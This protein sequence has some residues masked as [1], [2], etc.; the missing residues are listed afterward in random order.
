MRFTK[1]HGIG[2]DFVV[3]DGFKYADIPSPG[4]LSAKMC[5]RHFGVGADG[6]IWMMPSDCAD[7]RMRIFNSDGSEPE[8]CGN[9]LRCAVLF[10]KEKG[11]FGKRYGIP[12]VVL[13]LLNM[14][15]GIAAWLFVV[16]LFLKP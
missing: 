9:G 16:A 6:L 13:S 10:L 11:C 7:A 12:A 3:V 8:M 15:V 1:M 4:A 2:N 5:D 14:A